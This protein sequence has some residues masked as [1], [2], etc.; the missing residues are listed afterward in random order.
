MSFLSIF[1]VLIAAFAVFALAL[2]GV[3]A[4]KEKK[5]ANA[6][7]APWPFHAKKPLS[8]PE[9]VLYFRL[10]KALP[11]HIVL[12]QVSLSRLLG[13]NKGSDFGEWFNRISRMSADFVLCS[14]DSTI[15]AVVEL[16]DASHKKAHRELADAKKDKALQ[17]AG[18][19]IMRWQVNFIPDE[20]TIRATFAAGEQGASANK[21][22]S[23]RL[24]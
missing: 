22:D 9:Q 24:S 12:A 6:S 10:R 11:E 3:A 2:L 18:I 13:V 5:K 1:A 17:S 19:R 20:A 21:R 16:D 14:N 7:E 8:T 23:A 15:I 4:A